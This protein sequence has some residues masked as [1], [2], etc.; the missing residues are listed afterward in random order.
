MIKKNLPRPFRAGGNLCG[1]QLLSVMLANSRNRNKASSVIEILCDHREIPAF[2]RMT[3]P[4]LML[5]T[6]RSQV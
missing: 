5:I 1:M 6:P 2:A 3:V 4:K